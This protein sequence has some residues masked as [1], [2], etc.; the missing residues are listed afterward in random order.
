[1][2][3]QENSAAIAGRN[4]PGRIKRILLIRPVSNSVYNL[5]HAELISSSLIESSITD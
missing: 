1:M 5:P 3:G 2:R 4:Q